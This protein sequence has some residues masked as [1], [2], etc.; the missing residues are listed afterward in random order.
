MTARSGSRLPR[1]GRLRRLLGQFARFLVVGLVSFAFDYGLFFVLFQY[2]GVQYILASTI[3]FSLSLILNYVLT[4]KF[5]F[6]AQPGRSI[7]KEFA[8]YIGLNI[9]ALGLNQLI[10]FVT[11]DG[12]GI[13]PLI[14]KLIATAVVL[15]YNFTSRKLLIERSSGPRPAVAQRDGIGTSE[16]GGITS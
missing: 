5:V 15:V 4:L 7:V 1:D 13:D 16:T 10:L 11:V 14:G 9:I 6:E 3:S 2:F 8:I 12:V